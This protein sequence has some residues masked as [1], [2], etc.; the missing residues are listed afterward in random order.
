MRA[1]SQAVAAS[2]VVCVLAIS[3]PARAAQP[4]AAIE[5]ELDPQL[6]AAIVRAVGD[7]EAAPD[8]RF[9]ARR[10]A[11][12]AAGDAIAV[13]RAEGYYAYQVSPEIGDEDLAR[14]AVRITPGPR[15]TLAAPQIIWTGDAPSPD[16]I[17]AAMTALN[18][19]PGAPGRSADVVSAEGRAIAAIRKL[20]YAD[21]AARPRQVVV[22][23]ADHTVRPTFRIAAGAVS[24]LDGIQLA[25]EARTRQGWVSA[26]APWR[27][28]QTYDPDQVAELERRL[29]DT[30]VYDSVTVGLAPPD[31]KTTDGLT[32]VVVSLAERKRSTLELGASYDSIEGPGA[33]VRWTRY[34]VFGAGDTLT[35]I[36][37]GSHIDSRLEL[38]LS[39]PGWSHPLQ[40]LTTAAA[41]YDTA[42]DAYTERGVLV[43]ADVQHR[44]TRTSY[45]TW[46]GS[47]DV[48]KSEEI[49]PGTLTSLGRDLLT[50]GTLGELALDHTNDLLNPKQGWRIDL[51]AEP[52]LLAGKGTV[53]YLK[54]QAQA[55]AYLPVDRDARTV[56]AGRIHIGSIANG[57]VAEIPAP[58]RFYA[59]GGG[60]VRGFAYQ[61]VG[62]RLPDG[63]PQGGISVAEASLEVRRQVTTDWSVSTFVDAGTVGVTPFASYRN[64]GVGAGVGVAYNLGFGPIRVDLAAPVSGRHGGAPFEIYITLGQ[65]F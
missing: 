24:R 62:P 30:G 36:L 65:S 56:L 51:K 26:L 39:L 40:T 5:G 46:G 33:D 53:P 16:A 55:S 47:V 54:L 31:K 18:L 49:K 34:N 45:F 11:Q 19:Q 23:H 29:L 64:L 9:E 28:G 13:L 8:N 50:V 2:A 60:S 4:K 58:Q 21:A 48:S 27:S 12:A 44:F 10:R 14:P 3:A 6:R 38:D 7:S 59:G 25:G 61:G 57:T 17:R 15:F 32:P 63:T 42:T 20:G 43:R 1:L 37:R 22:D 52:T 41:V 35:T